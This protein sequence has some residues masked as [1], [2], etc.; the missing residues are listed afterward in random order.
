MPGS[1]SLRTKG[2]GGETLNSSA[3]RDRWEIP[4]ES[5]EWFY[6]NCS[7]PLLVRSRV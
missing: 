7:T 1:T 3:K 4:T 6:G 5:E 2:E